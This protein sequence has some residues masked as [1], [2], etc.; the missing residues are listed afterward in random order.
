[1]TVITIIKRIIIII[2]VGDMITE[3]RVI[4]SSVVENQ[5][6]TEI[7]AA[8]ETLTITDTGMPETT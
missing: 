4:L 7:I 1:M 6:K 2:T 5:V 3:D 8:T